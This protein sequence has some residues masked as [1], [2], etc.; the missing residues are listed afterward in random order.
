MSALLFLGPLVR[1]GVLDPRS[2]MTTGSSLRRRSVGFIVSFRPSPT[3]VRPVTKST[4]A[5]P[6]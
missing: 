1:A 4:M 3:R 5:R 6:G 2:G